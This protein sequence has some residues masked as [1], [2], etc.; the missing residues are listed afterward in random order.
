MPGHATIIIREQE[1]EK[2]G[3]SEAGMRKGGSRLCRGPG[4]PL[5]QTRTQHIR[6][7]TR[8]RCSSGAAGAGLLFLC[9]VAARG[10]KRAGGGRSSQGSS[11]SAGMPAQSAGGSGRRQKVRMKH[12][13]KA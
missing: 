2:S 10:E 1:E 8:L 9:P 11:T 3:S 5:T 4:L 6:R 7:N 12:P 13:S